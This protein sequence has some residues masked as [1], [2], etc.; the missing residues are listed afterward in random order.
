MGDDKSI[1]M[2]DFFGKVMLILFVLELLVQV[3]CDSVGIV[4]VG[5]YFVWDWLCFGVLK[6]IFYRF[7]YFGSY[8]MVMQ[9]LYWVF[10][11]L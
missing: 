2:I 7:Y 5:V 1:M 4:E 3:V 10:V 8:E 9:Y 11:V 6:V